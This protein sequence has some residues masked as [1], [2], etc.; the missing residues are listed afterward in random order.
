MIY[1]DADGNAVEGVLSPDE[2]KAVQ[3]KAAQ[4]DRY[5]EEL[6]KLKEK[7]FNFSE[8]RRA[9]EEQKEALLKNF[10]EKEKGFVR[11]IENTNKSNAELQK[12]LL[13]EHKEYVLR[14][15]S[16]GDEEYRKKIEETA[17]IK[18]GDEPL[19]KK[20]MEE[21]YL[22]AA[23]LIKGSRPQI[24]PLNRYSPVRE[25]HAPTTKE[26]FSRTPDGDALFREKFPKIAAI[27][28]KLKK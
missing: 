27:E 26:G 13:E 19:S 14:E 5:A 17:K 16:G 8:Y 25:Y 21:R 23:T 15:L 24:N 6:S 20:S 7:D 22:D 28:D 11:E 1:Y 12:T 2:A 10:T 3:E 18:F 9:T 4:A